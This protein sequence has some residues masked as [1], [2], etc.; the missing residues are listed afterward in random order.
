MLKYFEKWLELHTDNPEY[1]Q[2]KDFAKF[3]GVTPRTIQY[4]LKGV[5]KPRES[6][7]GIIRAYVESIS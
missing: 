3:V 1:Y 5:K 4:W 7:I 2:T 6:K